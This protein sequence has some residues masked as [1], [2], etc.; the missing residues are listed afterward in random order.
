VKEAAR[1]MA[2]GQTLHSYEGGIVRPTANHLYQR[3][4]TLLAGRALLWRRD[5]LDDTDLRLA[6][7]VVRSSAPGQRGHVLLAISEGF[8]EAK[9]IEAETRIPYD[10]IYATLQDLMRVG[11]VQH[12]GTAKT[13]ERGQPAIVWRLAAVPSDPEDEALRREYS[14]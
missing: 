1:L 5:E 8:R 11:V 6:Q 12:A 4:G 3:L 13:D 10:T 14:E 7:R 9:K 2:R